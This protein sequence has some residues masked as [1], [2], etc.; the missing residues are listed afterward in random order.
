M[1]DVLSLRL[2]LAIGG[3]VLGFA[4]STIALLWIGME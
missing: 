1:T 2:P 3:L 4:M